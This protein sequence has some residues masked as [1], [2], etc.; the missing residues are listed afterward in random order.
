MM[1]A[2]LLLQNYRISL[3]SGYLTFK[4]LQKNEE[5]SRKYLECILVGHTMYFRQTHKH[6]DR[7][8]NSH[9]NI[10]NTHIFYMPKN[11]IFQ[12]NIMPLIPFSQQG[13]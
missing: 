5:N 6:A 13:F 1:L 4:I 9:Y 10:D 3:T 12:A 11:Q 7:Q 2:F 8:T